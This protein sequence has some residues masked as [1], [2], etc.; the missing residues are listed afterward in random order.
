MTSLLVSVRNSDE[1]AAA[2]RGGADWIDVKEPRNGALGAADPIVWREVAA[3]VAGRTPLS[4][5]LGELTSPGAFTA[6]DL[7]DVQYAKVG[8]AGS[9]DSDWPQRW[10]RLLRRLP[11]HVQP[12][13]VLYADWEA[14]AAPPPAE[15]LAA[16]LSQRCAALLIDTWCKDGRHVFEVLPAATIAAL[17]GAA[18]A[19]GM[20]A[21]LGG[22]LT[23]DRLADAVAAGA[24]LVAVRGAAC[25]GAR[26][27][28]V[29]EGRVSELVTRLAAVS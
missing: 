10:R 1:A 18:S 11:S 16:A 3:V 21:V 19:A 7:A 22:S 5:A 27:S 17:L 4:A 20:R 26:D 8:L 25:D 13:A 15:V 14:A 29:C 12:V 23:A 6:A 24:Q 9:N 2:L 28:A